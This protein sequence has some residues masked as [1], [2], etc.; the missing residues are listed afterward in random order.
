[1]FRWLA[2][3]ATVEEASAARAALE[4]RQTIRRIR[5]RRVQFD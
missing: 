5:G 4:D 2:L 3:V 1:V